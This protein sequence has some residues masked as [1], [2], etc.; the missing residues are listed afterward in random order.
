MEQN[1]R[2]RLEWEIIIWKGE[3]LEILERKLFFRKKQEAFRAFESI[4]EETEKS[5]IR[6]ASVVKEE[7]I[8]CLENGVRKNYEEDS[9]YLE[10]QRLE[11][12]RARKETAHLRKI[13]D[14]AKEKFPDQ[15]LQVQSCCS[16]KIFLEGF[17]EI[18]KE[19]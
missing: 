7:K 19:F 15:M 6:S 13:L 3:K 1:V 9:N 14:K 11:T 10:C 4:M 8:L 18:R 5:K 17:S 16:D 2:W 12:H